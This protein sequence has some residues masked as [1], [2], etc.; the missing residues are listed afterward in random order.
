MEEIL[1]WKLENKQLRRSDLH[2]WAFDLGTWENVRQVVTASGWP[3]G[4][5]IE[6]KVGQK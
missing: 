2:N 3:L 6:W 1:Q 5:G 4:N